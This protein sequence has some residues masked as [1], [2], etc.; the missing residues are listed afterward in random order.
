MWVGGDGG[1]DDGVRG[2]NTDE[3][4][5]EPPMERSKQSESGGVW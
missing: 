3:S 2:N 5:G 4:M 1:I